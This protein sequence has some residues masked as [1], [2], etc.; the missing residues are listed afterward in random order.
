[1]LW[2]AEIAEA[3]DVPD[4]AGIECGRAFDRPETGSALEEG[5][6]P[7]LGLFFALGTE[8]WFVRLTGLYDSC[9]VEVEVDDE[10]EEDEREVEEFDLCTLLRGGTNMPLKLICVPFPLTQPLRGSPD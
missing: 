6:T 3:A 1:M 5:Q 10:D 9:T 7:L 8:S 2:S 4:D